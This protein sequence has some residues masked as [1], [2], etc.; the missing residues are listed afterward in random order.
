M[1]IV[2]PANKKKSRNAISNLREELDFRRKNCEFQEEVDGIFGLVKHDNSEDKNVNGNW[3]HRT[4]LNC[5]A[6]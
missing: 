6:L 3:F 2:Y 4:I 1:K 5:G